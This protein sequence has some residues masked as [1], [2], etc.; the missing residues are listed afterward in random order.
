MTN[1]NDA[2]K[3][4]GIWTLTAL[5]LGNMVG[6][7][8]F[9]LPSDLAKLGGASLLAWI[10]TSLGA[11][12]LAMVL[13][14]L[15][16]LVR[17]NGGPFAY[18]RNGLGNFIAFQTVYSHWVAIWVGNLGLVIAFVGYLAMT[19]SIFSNPIVSVVAGIAVIW[20]L[21]LVNVS[22][23]RPAGI[24]QLVTVILKL[25]PIALLLIFG[26]WYFD[27]PHI[28]RLFDFSSQMRSG[29]SSAASLTLWA[30]IGVESAVIPYSYV[31]NPHRNIPLATL[32][33]T[34]LAALVYILSTTIVIGIVP[35]AALQS[36]ASA[37]VVAAQMVFG[38][39]GKWFMLGG[40][41]VSCFGCINGWTLLQGQVAMAGAE[42]NLFP[43]VFGIRNKKGVPAKG[44][45]ITAV[46]ESVILLLTLNKD[47]SSKFQLVVLMASLA[48]LLPYLYS[49][50]A[51]LVILKRQ[52]GLVHVKDKILF[53]MASLLTIYSFWMMSLCG[54][55]VAFY[56]A[57]FIL[58]SA[59][60]YCWFYSDADNDSES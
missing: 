31:K 53:V 43:V 44:L 55:T 25:T 60:I 20:I 5:V 49:S 4:L 16:Q 30:F 58:T 32:I 54:T 3:P 36:G 42:N 1:F 2:K 56:G 34:V 10:I 57:I 13:S 18:A 27:V 45:I 19:W 35:A 14:R 37:F 59:L 26:L 50:L 47:M 40:A 52:T 41:L 23:V 8:I 7:G 33:G 6:S 9:L 29:I 15:S 22:G 28:E 17:Q 48:A 24:L 46:L 12:L 21:T 11:L 39:W 38:S 51:A